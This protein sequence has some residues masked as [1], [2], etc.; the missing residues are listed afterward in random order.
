MDVR[1]IITEALSRANIV[2]RR[3]AAPGDLVQSAF[4]LLKGIVSK[5]NNDNYLAFTQQGLSL[6]SSHRVMHIYGDTD[7]MLGEHNMVFKTA[8]ELDAYQPTEQD[9]ND[10]LWAFIND[11]QHD[12]VIYSVIGVDI[13]GGV[14][15]Q[16]LPHP[17][18]DP[19]SPRY[20]Q[21]LRYAKAYHVNVPDV[22]KLNTLAIDRSQ[23]YGMLKMSFV[24]R[25]DF[26]GCPNGDL[27]W[28]YN[29]LSQGEWE[30]EI[31]PY[32]VS[33]AVKLK[34][35]Y[36]RA[37]SFDLDSDLRIPDAYV[38]LLT[39]A[40]THK[41][42]IAYPRMDDA[43]VARLADEVRVML[44]NVRTPKA[45]SRQVLRDEGRYDE[46]GSYWGVMAG[47]MWGF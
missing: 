8:D 28:T 21:I 46:R 12:S 41:L 42:A 32:V 17:N 43:Q 10:G 20:Q 16:W 45:D 14:Q 19:F 24:P 37:L 9:F 30:I 11:G 2:P 22:Q 44:D 3:Q 15:Y 34:L 7:T 38:E 26:D 36:N 6:P 35:D 29:E 4:R 40:L 23:P 47:R 18:Q 25:A 31:K 27:V 5:Y 13:P 33:N 1:T 39:V